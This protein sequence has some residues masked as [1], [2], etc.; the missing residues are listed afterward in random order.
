MGSI[1]KRIWRDKETGKKFKGDAF[2]ISYFRDGKQIRESAGTSSLVE[3]KRILAKKDS[4]NANGIPVTLKMGRIKLSE[5]AANVMKELHKIW[6]KSEPEVSASQPAPARLV[7]SSQAQQ[8]SSPQTKEQAMIGPKISFKGNLTG[9]EDLLIEGSLEGTIE[10]RN[11]SVTIGKKG[12]IKADIYGKI[13]IIE[14]TVEGNLY[15]EERLIVR[16]S[17]TVT[18]KIDSPQVAL[19]IGCNF[20][21]SIDMSLK[22]KPTSATNSDKPPVEMKAT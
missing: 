12:Q 1:Y 9:E 13:I 11:H 8:S 16:P 4:D 20:N 21:G 10:M 18:G 6:K 2:W 22:D 14:G 5:L 7:Q 17:G 19:E 15:A 3:A